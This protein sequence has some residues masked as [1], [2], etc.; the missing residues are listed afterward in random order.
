MCV[1]KSSLKSANP[2]DSKGERVR[3]DITAGLLFGC[4]GFR[5]VLQ[6]WKTGQTASFIV[7][8]ESDVRHWGAVARR[9]GPSLRAMLFTAKTAS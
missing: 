7:G 1:C 3:E 5:F 8:S 2:V 9:P 4:F 6:G